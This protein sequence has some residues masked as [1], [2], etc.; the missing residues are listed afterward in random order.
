VEW[1]DAAE[2]YYR[3]TWDREE[4]LLSLPTEWQRELVA[5]ERIGNQ[6]C[7][8]GYLQFLANHGREMYEYASRALKKI[9]AHKSAKIIDTCQALIDEHFGSEGKSGDERAC[10]LPNRIINRKGET[11]KEAGSILP[12]SVL[13]RVSELSYEFMEFPDDYGT[14]A[15]NYYHSLIEADKDGLR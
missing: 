9:G 13:R 12:D 2:I 14:L 15:E 8:G 10:L 6:I 3:R 1:S 11:I 5:L 4:G 7:N